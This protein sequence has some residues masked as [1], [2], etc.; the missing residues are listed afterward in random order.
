[1]LCYWYYCTPWCCWYYCTSWW[2]SLCVL[3]GGHAFKVLSM[4]LQAWESL[5]LCLALVVICTSSPCRVS[6]KSAVMSS[7]VMIYIW[8]PWTP[9]VLTLDLVKTCSDV[10]TI[11]CIH[12]T[13]EL[14]LIFLS[15]VQRSMRCVKSSGE[16]FCKGR[17]FWRFLQ[18]DESR[19]TKFIFLLTNLTL[20]RFSG[21]A[22]FYRIIKVPG[23]RFNTIPKILTI[24]LKNSRDM[25]KL[26]FLDF[27]YCN[28]LNGSSGGF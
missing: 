13:M 22:P 1:M 11:Y 7:T 26:L 4:L 3:G 21:F 15:M 23:Q 25:Y 17:S 9:P 16:K 8:F 24:I 28:F 10:G 6:E 27:F 18:S 12:K 20:P 2:L 5:H 19:A 14:N